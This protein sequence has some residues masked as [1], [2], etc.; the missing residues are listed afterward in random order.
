VIPPAAGARFAPGDAVRV[1]EMEKEGH[2][3]TPDYAKGKPGWIAEALG[4]FPNPECLAYGGDGLPEKP[5]YKVGEQA[6]LRQAVVAVPEVG[7]PKVDIY[8]HWLQPREDG[9]GEKRP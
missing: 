6:V 4:A 5:L 1:R 9:G 7:L 3:R 2:V 8:E